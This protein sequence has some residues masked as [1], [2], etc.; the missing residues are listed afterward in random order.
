MF[1]RVYS[2]QWVPTMSLREG[3]ASENVRKKTSKNV[4]K[5]MSKNVRKKM[6]KNVRKKTSKNIRKKMSKN[7]NLIYNKNNYYFKI[8]KFSYIKLIESLKK[9]FRIFIC[10]NI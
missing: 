4:R 1:V 7:I 6:S 8:I 9:K 2:L 10:N 5:K 3:M